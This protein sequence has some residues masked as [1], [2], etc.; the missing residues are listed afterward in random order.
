VVLPCSALPS[1]TRYADFNRNRRH[2]GNTSYD[3]PGRLTPSEGATGLFSV[4]IVPRLGRH[5]DGRVFQFGGLNRPLVRVAVS[6]KL[7][8]TLAWFFR[9]SRRMDSRTADRYYSGTRELNGGG[10]GK[11][12]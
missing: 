1:E 12:T 3:G 11:R 7:G 4:L 10:A 9:P 6:T 8:I 2:A 5:D